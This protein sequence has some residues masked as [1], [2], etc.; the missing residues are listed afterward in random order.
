MKK[1]VI[2]GLMT[3]VILAVANIFTLGFIGITIVSI[4]FSPFRL[5]FSFLATGCSGESC[6]GPLILADSL[7]IVLVSVLLPLL[8]GL[9]YRHFVRKEKNNRTIYIIVC[10]LIFAGLILFSAFSYFKAV[11]LSNDSC[12]VGVAGIYGS[13]SIC[14]KVNPSTF[15]Y[16]DKE[17]RGSFNAF[18]VGEGGCYSKLALVNKDESFCTR[19]LNPR[20]QDRCYAQLSRVKNDISLCEKI[21]VGAYDENNVGTSGMN[22]FAQWDRDYC[23][24]NIASLTGD[25]SKCELIQNNDNKQLCLAILNNDESYCENIDKGV[26]MMSESAR[27]ECENYFK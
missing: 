19:S 2:I 27:I 13:D 6:L 8:F 20:E 9:S 23:Y 21:H 7:I 5:L 25:V 16:Y 10:D 11:C 22:S 15:F 24:K 1:T 3:G 4:L 12:V 14:K 18:S 17:N 26:F